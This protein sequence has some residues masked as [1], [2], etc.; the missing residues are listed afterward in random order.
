M[1]KL[2]ALL[3]AL[4]MV[5]ALA[6]CGSGNSVAGTWTGTVDAARYIA[7]DSPELKDYLKS[8]PVAITLELTTD[9]KYTINTDGTTMIPEFKQALRSYFENYCEENGVTV[10][11]LEDA[12]EMTLDE[13]IDGT[14]DEMDLSELTESVSG[15]YTATKDAIVFDPGA[16]NQVEG[17]WSGDTMHF[18]IDIGDVTLNRK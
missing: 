18:T 2:F 16:E 12:L 11:Q 14:F 17:T 4:C 6:A 3:L 15:I 9:G 5:A 7:S 10:E 13:L 1:K 8:A